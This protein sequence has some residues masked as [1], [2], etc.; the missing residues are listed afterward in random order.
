MDIR[1]QRQT[2][3][4]AYGGGSHISFLFFYFLNTKWNNF[5]FFCSLR[6]CEISH[7][8]IISHQ[9]NALSLFIQTHI[10]LQHVSAL[11]RHLQVA[12]QFE[13]ICQGTCRFNCCSTSFAR[14][15]LCTGHLWIVRIGVDKIRTLD[16]NN[17]TTRNVDKMW[18]KFLL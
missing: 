15:S 5:H 1:L 13:V 2:D 16:T 17:T 11:L 14:W 18:L 12:H 8:F 10:L 4:R 9:P 3:R 7:Y 6:C